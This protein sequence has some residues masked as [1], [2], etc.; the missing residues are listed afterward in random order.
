M[1]LK[2]KAIS[3]L[4]WILI[5]I[6]ILS[7]Y[8]TTTALEITSDNSLITS[9][10]NA[11]GYNKYERIAKDIK[12]KNKNASIEY[13]KKLQYEAIVQESEKDKIHLSFEYINK[14]VKSIDE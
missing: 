5:I 9:M 13:I 2:D 12:A 8:S 1:S 7:R 11:I 4:I 14:I 10:Y 3:C 6:N